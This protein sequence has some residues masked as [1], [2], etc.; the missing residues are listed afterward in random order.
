MFPVWSRKMTGQPETSKI[1][2]GRNNLR[3]AQSQGGHQVR[4]WEPTEVRLKTSPPPVLR[5]IFCTHGFFVALIQLRSIPSL[6]APDRLHLPSYC[7]RLC[8]PSLYYITRFK[9]QI[10]FYEKVNCV[11]KISIR[12]YNLYYVYLLRKHFIKK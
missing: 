3:Q 4:K 2:Q 9:K 5:E 11:K 10:I 6:Q 12:T 7:T 1:P 8:F